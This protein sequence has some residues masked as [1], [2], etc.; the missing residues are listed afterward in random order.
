MSSALVTDAPTFGFVQD[1]EQMKSVGLH[2][3]MSILRLC[4]AL[5]QQ[6]IK[7]QSPTLRHLSRTDRVGLDLL[8]DRI[9]LD[10]VIQSENRRHPKP[11]R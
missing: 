10:P 4:I 11:T 6:F 9:N 1:L 2:H 3:R 5:V 7:G 8:F